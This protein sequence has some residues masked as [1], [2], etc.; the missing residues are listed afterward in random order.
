MARNEKVTVRLTTEQLEQIDRLRGNFSR[1]EFLYMVILD[2]LQN[3]QVAI[4]S[5]I[6]RLIERKEKQ[7]QK[8]EKNCRKLSVR[9]KR[10]SANVNQIALALNILKKQGELS[11]EERKTLLELAIETLEL[12]RKIQL[13]MVEE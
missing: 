7:L 10:I 11:A 8:K 6:S 4:A 5:E 3:E 2:Y 13:Q 12:I 9:L 1:A